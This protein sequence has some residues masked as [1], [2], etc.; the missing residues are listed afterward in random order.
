M[1]GDGDFEGG[2]DSVSLELRHNSVM[3]ANDL[4]RGVEIGVQD[5]D[6]LRRTDPFGQ[7]GEACDIDK[8]YGRRPL[9]RSECAAVAITMS[10]MARGTYWS[11]ISEIGRRSASV[12]SCRRTV[13]WRAA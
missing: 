3:C 12:S 9:C 7:S 4:G 2:Q 1:V 10:V 11:K 6:C 8:D 13:R 5:V